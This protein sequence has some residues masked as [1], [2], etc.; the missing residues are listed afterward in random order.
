M[1]TMFV[2]RLDKANKLR[3]GKYPIILQITHNRKITKKRL[4]L[5]ATFDQWDFVNHEYRK[6]VHGRAELNR[7]LEENV[8]RARKIYDTEFYDRPFTY[9]R[10]IEYFDKPKSR[11]L[12]V[13]DF[14]RM[15]S[16]DFLMTGQISS[17]TDYKT[18]GNAIG[19]LG[20]LDFEDITKEWLLKFESHYHR[21][22]TN[23][24]SYM[25]LLK[26]L[27]MKA[28]Q[29]AVVDVK[30]YPFRHIFFNPFGYQPSTLKKVKIS[31][32]NN[33]RIKDIGQDDLV[34][35]M[36]YKP[37]SDNERK[38][39]DYWFLSYYMFGVNFIDIA[40]MQHRDIR[41]G[42]WYYS[43][44]KTGVSLGGKPLSD[45]V[46]EIIDRNSTSGEFVFDIFSESDS[47]SDRIRHIN[48]MTKNITKTMKRI[49]KKLGIN[50]YFTFYSARHTATTIALNNGADRNTV[51]KLL[52][53][54]HVSTIDNYAGNADERNIIRAMELLELKSYRL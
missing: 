4:G 18:L 1:S 47:E 10:F 39:L 42:K 27:Y 24:Y 30:F 19:Q 52:D 48:N 20:D 9:S 36:N 44:S 35:I 8:R 54:S 13:L 40:K 2:I 23:C 3:D 6:G 38:C 46:L 11:K 16:D 12:S 28:V 49:S 31:R 15:V 33:R 21:K 5:S 17:S 14:C 7:E 51:S 37:Q 53:H 34:M 32:T 29:K 50:G 22:G 26:I 43:R 25:K 45:K 41:G